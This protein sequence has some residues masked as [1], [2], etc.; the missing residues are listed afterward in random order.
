MSAG[1]SG[2][3]LTVL[4]IR[5]IELGCDGLEIEFKDGYQEITAMKGNFGFGIGQIKS[6]TREVAALRIPA[7]C[8]VLSNAELL[9]TRSKP[10]E[11]LSSN[12]GLCQLN[13]SA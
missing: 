7:E 4:L 13:Y 2:K 8:I 9:S 1:Y 12:H 3:N 11:Q 5:A 6:D 10:I